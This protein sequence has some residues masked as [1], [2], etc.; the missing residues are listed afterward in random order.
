MSNSTTAE[1]ADIAGFP[2]KL[3]RIREAVAGL[4]AVSVELSSIGD[5]ARTE[6]AQFTRSGRPAPIYG[7]A[8][9][10]LD[11]WHR[12]AAALNEALVT[13]AEA[14]VDAAAAKFTAITGIDDAGAG[15][16]KKL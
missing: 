6:A 13:A 7:D 5:T 14:A 4:R 2:A 10:G 16:I 9:R 11:A 12:N 8:L 15:A 3:N 1:I